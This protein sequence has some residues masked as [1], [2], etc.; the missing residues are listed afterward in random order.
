MERLHFLMKKHNVT[1]YK[2]AK[3]IGVPVTTVNSWMKGKVKIPRQKYIHKLSEFF[4]VSPVWLIYGDPAQKPTPAD[5]L[6]KVLLEAEQMGPEAIKFLQKTWE[7]YKEAQKA[8]GGKG[9][10]IRKT[11]KRKTA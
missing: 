2:L 8:Y 11:R 10:P 5:D 6:R 4:N 9:H 7:A 1:Q 3:S